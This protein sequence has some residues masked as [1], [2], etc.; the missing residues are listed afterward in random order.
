MRSKPI[1]GKTKLVHVNM[2]EKTI[3]KVQNIQRRLHSENK[4]T[5]IRAS[6]DIAE[7]ITSVISKGGKV[8]LDEN[9]QK[10]ILKVPGVDDGEQ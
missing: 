8:I 10:Y 9:G 7:M 2:S 6:I 4:T 3:D 1:S 5:A